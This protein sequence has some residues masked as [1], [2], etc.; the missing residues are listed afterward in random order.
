MRIVICGASG[1]GKTT[2]ADK[3]EKELGLPVY[4]TDDSESLQIAEW[5]KEDRYIVEGCISL[6]VLKHFFWERTLPPPCDLFIFLT[7]PK[8]S[9]TEGQL[10]QKKA[11]DSVHKK[12]KQWLS[13]VTGTA[14]AL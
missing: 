5:L 14:P 6:L 13:A 7:E 4:H 2:L 12:L 8:R 3:L 10:I 1:T 11:I 9:Q